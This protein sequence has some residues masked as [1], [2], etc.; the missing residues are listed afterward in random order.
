MQPPCSCRVIQRLKSSANRS[1]LMSLWKDK[2]DSVS[3][4][5]KKTKDGESSTVSL[6][7]HG[8]TRE[9]DMLYQEKTRFM[10]ALSQENHKAE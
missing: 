2:R 6:R 7:T 5:S 1:L 8:K 3:K 9:S 4:E 10:D